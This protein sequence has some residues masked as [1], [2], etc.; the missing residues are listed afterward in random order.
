[1]L[2]QTTA[3]NVSSAHTYNGFG[4]P[5]SDKATFT[6]PGTAATSTL[7]NAT[8]DTRDN[9]GRIT[10]KTETVGGVTSTYRYTYDNRGRLENVTKD[11]AVYRSYTYD[12]N[13]NR[14]TFSEDG[15]PSVAGT[16]D[17]QDRLKT[18]GE[19]S[20]THTPDGQLKT[21]TVGSATTTYTYD[22]LGNLTKVELPDK[23]IDYVVDGLGRRVAKKVDGSV[24][25]R[26]VYGQGIQPIAEMNASGGIKSQFVYASRSH[27][28][29]LMIRNGTTYRFVADQVGSVRMVVNTSDG[30]VAQRIDYDPF[31]RVLNDSNPRFQ[32]FGFAG[33]LYDDDTELVRFGARDYD[34]TAGRWTAKDPIRFAAGSPNLF[35]YASGDPINQFDPSGLKTFGLCG[36]LSIFGDGEEL[37]FVVDDDG[38]LGLTQSSTEGTQ[39]PGEFSASAQGQYSTGDTIYKLVGTTMNSALE[40]DPSRSLSG[41][42]R[43]SSTLLPPATAPPRKLSDLRE[44]FLLAAH[45]LQTFMSAA[46]APK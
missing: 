14:L 17:A 6:D 11:G 38:N 7:Y 22:E 10:S 26:F 16:Y 1:M 24:T 30:I 8:Y 43:R 15:G 12:A 35:R 32:P 40:W 20:Y 37:C 13:G 2:N 28:P 34:S 25:D 46:A 42:V 5:S 23:T 39:I 44:A 21:R 4:E 36:A 18:Y 33:G 45:S 19:A 27:V 31:G 3:A 29:D 9:L 41:P